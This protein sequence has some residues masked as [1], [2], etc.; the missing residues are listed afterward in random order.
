MDFLA[1]MTLLWI[2]LLVPQTPFEALMEQHGWGP[3]QRDPLIDRA[4]G[5]LARTVGESSEGLEPAA[6]GRHLRF[7]LVRHGVSDVQVTPFT[8]RGRTRPELVKHLPRLFGRLKRRERP[9]HYGT[10]TH[11]SGLGWTTTLLLVHRGAKVDGVLPRQA[12]MN[13]RFEFTGSLRRGYYTPRLIVVSPKGQY[14]ERVD[15]RHGRRFGYGFPFDHGKGIYDI[16]L[17]AD[18]QYGPVVLV[19]HRVY[20]GMEPPKLPTLR[21]RPSQPKSSVEDPAERLLSL[22]NAH[23]VLYRL[24]PLKRHAG[25]QAI[26]RRHAIE[27]RKTKTLSHASPDTGTLRTR[28]KRAGIDVVMVAENLAE[29]ADEREAFDAFLASPGHARNQLLPDVTHVGVASAGRY[30]AVTMARLAKPGPQPPRLEPASPV[31]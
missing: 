4:A 18:S 7:A 15:A 23:R 5:E 13:S 8:V 14:V 26:A 12:P 20:V 2:A 11:K 22:V 16:E 21:L 19:R 30:F 6:M 31:P 9:T 25:L 27:M 10:A 3:V 17:V 28:V 1:H 24:N 29:A